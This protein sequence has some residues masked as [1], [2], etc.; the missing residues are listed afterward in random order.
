MISYFVEIRSRQSFPRRADAGSVHHGVRRSWFG[1]P[2][3]RTRD[4][5]FSFGLVLTNLE[6]YVYLYTND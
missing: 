4:Q 6:F 2:M 5:K 1:I 3:G